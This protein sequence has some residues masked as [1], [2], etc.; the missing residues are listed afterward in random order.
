MT[1]WRAL[2][3]LARRWYVVLAVALIAA[4][5]GFFALRGAGVYTAQV[6]VRLLTPAALTS[7]ENSLGVR[8]EGLAKFAALIEKQFNGNDE[9]IR[10]GSP[11][12]TLAGAGV[13]SGVSVRLL[14]SGSQWNQSFRE[15]LLIVDVVGTSAAGVTSQVD[16]TV[17]ELTRIISERQDDAGIDPRYSVT[18]LVSPDPP[19]VN[20]I[21]GNRSRALAA[22]GIL[23][24]GIAVL[25]AIETDRLLL[26]RSAR[27]LLSA[28]QKATTRAR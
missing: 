5:A 25:A 12:A 1:V 18:T 4:L 23:G 3:I 8:P 16:S 24:L 26:R 10:F 21:N 22:I 20:Y 13:R 17:A 2:G 28:A 27:N 7:D 15:P 14:N 6:S 11:D 9:I 19:A